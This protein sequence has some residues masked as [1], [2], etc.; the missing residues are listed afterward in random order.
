MRV[1]D[2]H[3]WHRRRR[4]PKRLWV[5]RWEHCVIPIGVSRFEQR[6]SECSTGCAEYRLHAAQTSDGDKGANRG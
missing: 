4:M 2:M 3:G 5:C 1:R 6:C